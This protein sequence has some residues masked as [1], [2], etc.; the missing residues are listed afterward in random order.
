MR[1]MVIE[2]L[3]PG[4]GE[5]RGSTATCNGKCATSNACGRHFGPARADRGQA[6]APASRGLFSDF[7][8][9]GQAAGAC[10]GSCPV[11]VRPARFTPGD[12]ACGLLGRPERGKPHA[13]DAELDA[14]KVLLVRFDCKGAR[15]CPEDKC[16]VL[17]ATLSGISGRASITSTGKLLPGP[18]QDID[19]ASRFRVKGMERE[20]FSERGG[21]VR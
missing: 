18:V 4:E 15:F 16:H 19:S 10:T 13:A 20:V 3:S 17:T 5:K 2:G 21:I 11:P 1:F 12:G 9:V 14:V 8:P 6:A 7:F